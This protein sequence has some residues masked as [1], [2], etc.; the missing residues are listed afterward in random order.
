MAPKHMDETQ[1]SHPLLQIGLDVTSTK[2][3]T[4]MFGMGAGSNI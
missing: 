3:I 4:K 1:N 2:S